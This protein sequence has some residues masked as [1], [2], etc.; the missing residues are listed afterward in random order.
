MNLFASLENNNRDNE[1]LFSISTYK[2]IVELHN[3]KSDN[4]KKID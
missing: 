2:S 3:I 4:R 1:Y